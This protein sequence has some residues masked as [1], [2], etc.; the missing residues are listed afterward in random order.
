MRDNTGQNTTSKETS[1]ARARGGGRGG[2]R[3]AGGGAV[4]VAVALL[5]GACGP[6]SSPSS[7]GSGGSGSANAG[8]GGSG[9]ANTGGS[10]NQQQKVAFAHCMRSHGVPGFPDPTSNGT[11]SGGGPGTFNRSSPQFQA[12]TQ[13]CKRLLPNGGEETQ[14]QQQRDTAQLLRIAQCM[15]SHGVPNFSDPQNVNGQSQLSMKASG[16]GSLSKFQ[17]AL[18]TCRSLRPGGGS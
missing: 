2:P 13:A 15:R 16:S 7:T 6:G 4:A 18:R 9:S 12:A 10:P 5:L 11:F 3:L 17:S 1:R 8:S 14:A